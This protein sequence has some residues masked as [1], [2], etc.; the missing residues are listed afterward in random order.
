M[1]IKL[2]LCHLFLLI[3]ISTGMLASCKKSE[4]V[5]KSETVARIDAVL[6]ITATLDGSTEKFSAAASSLKSKEILINFPSYFPVGSNNEIDLS[7]VKLT[8]TFNK[9]IKVI[10]NV[11]ALVDLRSPFLIEIQNIDG[12]NEE[13]NIKANLQQDLDDFKISKGINLASW[14]ST[15]KYSGA[16]RAA[17]FTEADVKLLSEQGF[18]HIR[19]CVDEVQLW[20]DSGNKIREYGFNLLH[21]AI[22]WCIKYNVRAIID[23]H[24][25]RNHRF[26]NAE[27][28]LFTDPAEPAKFVK[29]WEDLSDELKSYPN[30]LVAYELLN[31]P[32]SKDAK[33]WNRVSALAI[34]AIRA[35]EQNR[36]IIVGVCTANGS[37]KYSE[38][39]LPSNHR[40]LSTFHYYGPYLLT[41]YGLQS[42]T[43]GRKDIPMTYPGRLVP[44]E[45]ISALPANWQETGRRTYDKSV[46]TA[47]MKSG[48][49]MAKRLNVPV[50]VGEF[51][52]INVTPEPAR[53]NW[54]KDIVAICKENNAA[55]TSFDYKGAGYSVISEGRIPL[56]PNLINIILD[57]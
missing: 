28:T 22:K 5:E 25:T 31:E 4:T 34:N 18:D 17:F 3:T 39:T 24:I 12:N 46:L 32:V 41:A 43:G 54:Y 9:G 35:K 36:T 53:S 2:L 38:L 1:K 21:D 52:T 29:L 37:V 27:N 20:D 23:M 50:F 8:I 7:K 49:D 19:I 57:K 42:T 13:I 33:N 6:S 30:S 47:N 16:A 40:I 51:G 45:W 56:Y 48:F 14:L 15:P 44:E 11:P 55:Y 26:T 10:T